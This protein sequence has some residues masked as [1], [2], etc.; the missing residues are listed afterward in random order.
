MKVKPWTWR[1]QLGLFVLVFLWFA[2]WSQVHHESAEYVAGSACVFFGTA[3]V[4][5]R[6]ES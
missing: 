4:F 3:Y 5:T 6:N 2:I 1:E